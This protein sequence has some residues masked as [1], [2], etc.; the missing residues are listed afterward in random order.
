M[1]KLR[2]AVIGVGYLGQYHAE[3]YHQL[4]AVELV[5]V[6]D[7]DAHACHKI[8]QKLGV[9]TLSDYRELAE[10]VDL[11]SIATPTHCHHEVASFFIAHG[12]HVLLEKP[13][14]ISLSQADALI[15]LAERH[16]VILQ[17]G[18]LERFNPAFVTALPLIKQPRWVDITRLSPFKPR[19]LDVDV[20]LDLMIHDIE[21]I[22]SL[23]NSSPGQITA[24][25]M[26]VLSPTLDVASAHFRL[27]HQLVA[28]LTA[29]RISATTERKWRV[30]QEDGEILVDFHNK[31]VMVS[32]KNQAA[33]NMET[34]IINCE[35]S[36]ALRDEISS[37]VECVNQNKQPLVDGQAGRQALATALAVLEAAAN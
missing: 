4:P 37:F 8:G 9:K 7:T 1:T 18:H 32:R 17:I 26:T 33:D 21:M 34:Q 11:V 19:C 30:I 12:V 25:G 27:G 5:A 6:C 13:I 10:S 20:V 35:S 15:E 24:S 2:A 22:Q 16:Q 31:Q 36:D 28:N 14:A 3:K 29:S 23:F